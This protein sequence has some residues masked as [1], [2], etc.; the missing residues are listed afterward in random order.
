MRKAKTPDWALKGDKQIML[1][2]VDKAQMKRFKVA[3]MFWQ[4]KMSTLD[5]AEALETTQKSVER[6]L[7]KLRKKQ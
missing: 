1:R 5:I 6:I 2:C 3:T 4:Q 7:H